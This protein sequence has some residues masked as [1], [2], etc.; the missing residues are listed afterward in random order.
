MG[1]VLLSAD[2]AEIC[3]TARDLCAGSICSEFMSLALSFDRHGFALLS[4]GEPSSVLDL[5]YKC[6][7][8]G[9]SVSFTVRREGKGG[10]EEVEAEKIESTANTTQYNT[11]ATATA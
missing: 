9:R 6:T 4:R 7:E 2:L 1:A 3:G 5:Q 11:T 10:A 8:S